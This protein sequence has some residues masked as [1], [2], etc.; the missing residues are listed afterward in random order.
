MR[1][2]F[3]QTLSLLMKDGCKIEALSSFTVNGGLT[4]CQFQS[5]SK[6]DKFTGWRKLLKSILQ[7]STS[8]VS[9]LLLSLVRGGKNVANCTAFVS[10]A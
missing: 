7:Q 9:M 10:L 8:Q 5:I 2:G 1:R 3:T 6:S 4:A